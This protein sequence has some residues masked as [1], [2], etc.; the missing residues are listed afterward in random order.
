MEFRNIKIIRYEESIY[1][2]NVDNF[3]YKII[4]QIGINPAQ[5][6]SKINKDNANERKRLAQLN[7][8]R[9]GFKFT[10]TSLLQKNYI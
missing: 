4:K 7:D 3:K 2:A 10:L 5:V 8:L 9:V 1:Y 6:I